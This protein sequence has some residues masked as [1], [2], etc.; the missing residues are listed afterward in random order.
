MPSLSDKTCIDANKGGGVFRQGHECVLDWI[1]TVLSG[2]DITGV[3]LLSFLKLIYTELERAPGSAERPRG[4]ER[5]R[6]GSDGNSIFSTNI[7]IWLLY[8]YKL[9]YVLM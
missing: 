1:N 2:S 7:D 6:V 3:R 4:L 9:A 8:E 5:P